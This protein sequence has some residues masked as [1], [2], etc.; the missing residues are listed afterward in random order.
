MEI[1]WLFIVTLM[2]LLVYIVR[3]YK[4]GC[5]RV[6]FSLVALVLTLTVVCCATP[7]ISEF[8]TEKTTIHQT[9][10]TGCEEQIRESA[11]ETLG[12]KTDEYVKDD[13]FSSI[14]K[15][16]SSEMLESTGMYGEVAGGMADFIVRGISFFLALILAT[17]IKNIIGKAI[18]IVS[19]LPIIKG[20]NRLLGIG[21]GF[22]QG[23]LIIWIFF[24]F[25]EICQTYTFGQEV[26]IC[27][28]NNA[29]LQV[30]YENNLIVDIMTKD[31]LG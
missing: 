23:V 28:E 10:K 6:I 4:R 16:S 17:I 26:M 15:N 21:A 19:K 25:I 2:I 8:L 12:Q 1:N 31:M 14:I 11:T 3:G 22:M 9:I 20:V 7:Y 27:V 13:A 18:D 5:L 24:Y 30:L 29:F